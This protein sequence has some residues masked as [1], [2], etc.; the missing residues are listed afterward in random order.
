MRALKPSNKWPS[1]VF[2]VLVLMGALAYGGGKDEKRFTARAGA[3][4]WEYEEWALDNPSWSG[5]E[6]DLVATVTF[7][8]SNTG[9]TH[10]TE[11]FY[12]GSNTWKFR[13]TGTR[14]GQWTFTTASQDPELNGYQG[15]VTVMPNPDP[16]IKGFLTHVGNKYAI[17]TGDNA[18]F[19]GYLFNVYMN[20]QEF[21]MQYHQDKPG[22][23]QDIDRVDDYFDAAAE[24]GFEIVFYFLTHHV[25]K[26]GAIQQHEHGSVNPDLRTF[27]HLDYIIRYSH[28]RGG[29]VHFWCWGDA[30]RRQ[31]PKRLPGGINGYVDR[32]LQRYIAARLGPLPGWSMGYGYDLH[33]WANNDQLNAWAKYMHDHLG[34]QHLLSARGRKLKGPYNIISY[35]GFGRK[36]EITTTNH[37]PKNYQEVL[38]DLK[39]DT[40]QPH[41]Y[42]ERHTYLRDGFDLGMD[43]SRRLLWRLAMAGGMGGFF[44][45]YSQWFNKW[46]PYKG[47]YPN[48]E[49][50]RTHKTFWRERF[51]LDMQRANQLC[52]SGGCVLKDSKSQH[53]VI[54]QEDTQSIQVDLP[55]MA[56][57]QSAVAVD[58]RKEYQE[59]ALGRLQ[60]KQQR[61]KLPNKSDWVIAIGK[62]E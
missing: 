43:G 60:P 8:H 25:F 22:P 29:R 26:L 5:N 54:Y 6:Y 44:G 31:T 52:L 16:K 50:F 45:Y 35:S 37:G 23:I 7:T 17:Q 34:W 33:E 30:A 19:G 56:G 51:L 49:Q 57:G 39:A 24:N 13:F 18:E 20:Q 3:T 62:F 36:N 47:K 53:Y 2:M 59:I 12:D 46:G 10:T 40:S 61:I 4:M 55:R 58:T 42:E 41:L 48:P 27:R 32:R 1:A 21:A 38:E 11:M 9:S 14:T 28:R 15:S